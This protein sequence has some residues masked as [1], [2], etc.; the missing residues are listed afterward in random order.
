[1]TEA[2]LLQ[3]RDRF[4]NMQTE[5]RDGNSPQKAHQRVLLPGIPTTPG[6]ASASARQVHSR[7]VAFTFGRGAIGVM[8]NEKPLLM[9]LLWSGRRNTRRARGEQSRTGGKSAGALACARRCDAATEV[10]EERARRC[11]QGLTGG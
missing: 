4:S 5:E 11:V 10:R 1:M 2:Q 6:I 9:S 7:P 3:E 8:G